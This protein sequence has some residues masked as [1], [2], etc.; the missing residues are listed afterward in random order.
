[1]TDREE[2]AACIPWNVL[3]RAERDR[4]WQNID[5]YVYEQVKRRMTTWRTDRK[6][7]HE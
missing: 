5:A 7:G 6:D 4:I 3:N 1:M 2:A